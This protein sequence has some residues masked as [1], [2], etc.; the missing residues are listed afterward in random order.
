[1]TPEAKPSVTI[2]I[3]CFN[4]SQYLAECLDSLLASDYRDWEAIVVDDASTHGDVSAVVANCGDERIR[5]LRHERN[6][7]LAAA[8]NSAFYA[9]RGELLLPLDSDDCLDP[10]FLSRTVG[11]LEA[12]PRVDCAY[13]DLS[14]FGSETGRR[15]LKVPDAAEMLRHSGRTIPGAGVLMRRSLWEKV[16]GYCEDQALRVGHEDWD[17]WIAAA[18]RGLVAEHIPEPLYRYRRTPDSMSGTLQYFNIETRDFIYLRHK[19]FFDRYEAGSAFLADGC[20]RSALAARE[21]KEWIRAARLVVR[22]CR[23][24]PTPLE[25]ARMLVHGIAPP[26]LK[27]ILVF[28]KR[29]F[30]RLSPG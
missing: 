28:G 6:R 30:G 23:I 11:V 1:M 2:G 7:G 24:S 26:W 18:A 27:R 15:S 21:R 19:D 10:L 8:R 14:L 17:F 20:V 9:G 5:V 25:T 12:N 16:G 4:Q 22:A 3:P 29:L 13:A